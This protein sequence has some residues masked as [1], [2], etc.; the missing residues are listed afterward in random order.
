VLSLVPA[1]LQAPG[2]GA[3]AGR[4]P[5]A[6]AALWASLATSRRPARA[7]PGASGSVGAPS[8]AA[9]HAHAGLAALAALG[10]E[11][12]PV[13]VAPASVPV[14]GGGSGGVEVAADGAALAG[15]PVPAVEALAAEVAAELGSLRLLLA[16]APA[17]QV[18]TAQHQAALLPGL[19]VRTFGLIC[20]SFRGD[21]FCSFFFSSR[22][23]VSRTL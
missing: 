4:H 12:P 6:A 10:P 14:A 8:P 1:L 3:S 21:F 7:S 22:R 16:S 15:A 19:Q 23:L 5:R 9:V 2:W 18:Q 11:L 13:V 17:S 20:N